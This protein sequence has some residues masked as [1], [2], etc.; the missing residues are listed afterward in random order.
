MT[1]YSKITEKK[2]T[3]AKNNLNQMN[4]LINIAN[5]LKGIQSEETGGQRLMGILNI[6]NSAKGN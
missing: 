5:G 4:S 6:I 3:S 2:Q 1:T